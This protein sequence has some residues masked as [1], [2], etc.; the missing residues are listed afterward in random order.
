MNAE[1]L[2]K[3]PLSLVTKATSITQNLHFFHTNKAKEM[4]FYSE[5]NLSG[6]RTSEDQLRAYFKAGCQAYQL[7]SSD[8]TAFTLDNRNIHTRTS[9]SVG[10]CTA[11]CL[12]ISASNFRLH[13]IRT[14]TTYH[15]SSFLFPSG[16]STT[17][18]TITTV[19]GLPCTTIYG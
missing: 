16:T 2:K 13:F 17:N 9:S 7:R 6:N 14:S 1:K 5:N 8:R 15:V 18:Y 11:K 4:S 12:E 3:T 19:T 10:Y